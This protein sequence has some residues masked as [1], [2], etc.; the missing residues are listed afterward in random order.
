MKTNLVL[1]TALLS[2]P[3]LAATARS[4]HEPPGLQPYLR[5]LR[6]AGKDPVTFVLDQLRD[7]DLLIFDDGLHAALEPFVF[8]QQLVRNP[9]FHHQVKYV[10]LEVLPINL[11][12]HI[13]AYLDAPAEDPTLLYPA[14]QNSTDTG[15]PCKT[16][17][18]LLHAIA[19]RHL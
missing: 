8:Y 3:L 11:Q 5:V 10:F 13:D 4:D 9:D 19:A 16:Y 14:F 17:F 12:P 15:F 2:A 7:H 18:D 1:A 6:E